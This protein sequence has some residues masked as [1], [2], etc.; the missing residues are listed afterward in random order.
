M[1]VKATWLLI[2]VALDSGG[3]IIDGSLVKYD[4]YLTENQC[5]H[6]IPHL[7]D[8]INTTPEVREA[9]DAINAA[10]VKVACFRQDHTQDYKEL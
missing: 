1:F 5:Q 4:N 8:A 2:S 7:T 6:M 3:E 10:S 9:Y